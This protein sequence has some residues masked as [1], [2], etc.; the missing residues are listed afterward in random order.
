MKKTFLPLVA[1]LILIVALSF[2]VK[3]LPADDQDSKDSSQGAGYTFIRDNIGLSVDDEGKMTQSEN[4]LIKIIDKKGVERFSQVVRTYCGDRQEVSVIMARTIQPDGTSIQVPSTAIEDGPFPALKGVPLYKNLRVKIIKFPQVKE[5]SLVEYQ[6]KTIGLKPYPGQ[7]FWETSF[8]QDMGGLRETSFFLEVPRARV[9]HYFTPGHKNGMYE[10][11]VSTQGG[12]KIMTWQFRNVEP[13]SEEIAMPPV[14]DIASRILVGSFTSWDEVGTL[15]RSLM[16][17]HL[18]CTA[19]MKEHFAR[20]VGNTTGEEA[21]KKIYRLLLKEREVENIGF[22]TGGYEFNDASALYSEKNVISRD[23]ALLVLALLRDAG[24]EA[25][26][27]L[28]GSSAMG[29]IYREIPII[30]QFDTVLVMARVEGKRYWIDGTGVSTELGLLPSEIQG[31][32]ALI[33]YDKGTELTTTPCSNY[34]ANREELRGEIKLGADGSVDGVIKM[35][36]YGANKLQWQRIYNAVG[37]KEKQ[38]LARVLASQVNPVAMV[39]DYTIRDGMYEEVPF[40]IMMRFIINDF[41]EKSN[42]EWTSKLPLMGGGEMKDLLSIDASKRKWPIVVGSAFQ[43]DRRFHLIVP[44]SVSVK[45]APR[46]LLKENS[47]GSFQVVCNAQGSDINYYSRLTVK[48]GIV[49]PSEAPALIEILNAAVEAQKA[50]ITFEK[51][52]PL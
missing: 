3:A 26:P 17:S 33:V 38:N 18:A 6:L 50:L 44:P 29:G 19:A 40:S 46:T 23:F 8:T 5:G 12:R 41:I 25:Y 1:A 34:E 49:E 16:E 47:V 51:R 7:P 35:S 20:E 2:P 14:Q 22:G 27:V 42:D 11:R 48:K 13:I 15:L 10:P 32:P 28:V 24:I 52:S 43:E 30:Q 31:R 37:T 4:E 39:L 45:S 36:E 9:V 21:L